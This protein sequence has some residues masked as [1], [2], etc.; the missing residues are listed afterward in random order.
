MAVHPIQS[1]FAFGELS[2]RLHGRSN[3]ER[4]QSSLAQCIDTL[5]FSHGMASKRAGTRLIT[6]SPTEGDIRFARLQQ[7]IRCPYVAEFGWRSGTGGYVRVL[8]RH[9]YAKA[10]AQYVENGDFSRRLLGWSD[11]SE[12]GASVSWIE[13]GYAV[14]SPRSEGGAAWAAIRREVTGVVAA[15]LH[16]LTT[17]WYADTVADALNVRVGTT[18]GA[19]D[20][21]SFTHGTGEQS[22]TFTPPGTSFWIELRVLAS[23]AGRVLGL[24][25]VEVYADAATV[26]EAATPY[27]DEDLENLAFA[28]STT[29]LAL[30]V[31]CQSQPPQKLL[32]GAA[33]AI[34]FA[35]ATI[36]SP[37]AAWGAGD[38]PGAVAFHKRRLWLA[39]SPSAPDTLWASKVGDFTDFGLGTG[40]ATDG[41]A[42]E[43]AS[44]GAIQWL[45]GAKN[46]LVGLDVGEHIITSDGGVVIP[47]D[48]R[49]DEQSGYGSAR[50]N[51]AKIG[52]GVLYVGNDQR[53]VRFMAYQFLEEG[54][55]STD[56]TWPSEH[57]TES[58]IRELH[59]LYAPD[60][61]LWIVRN[62]GRVVSAIY[63]REQNNLVGWHQHTVA[64]DALTAEL[65]KLGASSELWLGVRRNGTVYVERTEARTGYAT[66][67]GAAPVPLGFFTD[68]SVVRKVLSDALGLY[69][70]NLAHL[71]GQSVQIM[72]GAATHP[73]R[74]VVSGV[75]RLQSGFTFAGDLVRVGR[76]YEGVIETLPLEGIVQGGTA[77][78]S[79]KRQ[80]RVFVRLLHSWMP[81]V[82][83][84]ATETRNPATPMDEPEPLTTSD[85]DVGVLGLDRYA[86]V[87]ITMP[88]PLPYNV[89]AL[90]S[91][92]TGSSL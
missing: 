32:I 60:P 79:K 30:Y 18:P 26:F 7:D 67:D 80:H 43:M 9:G 84:I 3:T 56:I 66:A 37:P 21:A 35:A 25:S 55:V 33:G 75:V 10:A 52:N 53:R 12:S 40:T 54:W 69:V 77:Q 44:D 71:E 76:G 78:S 2:P 24:E 45:A 38:Y 31:A 63:E 36:T 4:Y 27:A 5:T 86:K 68:A 89:L 16:R 46:L 15:A 87:R 61:F 39:G 41:I 70:D 22:T 51:A 92:A 11:V 17:R 47:G 91:D 74:T 90:F 59:F 88:R 13:P 14:F 62:D 29:E 50:Q 81:A 72:T 19:T 58:G 82:N 8:N 20:I 42:F 28:S 23:N 83:G 65:T 1:S 34:S 85:V 64:T 6:A 49:A 73:D 57:I 48:I